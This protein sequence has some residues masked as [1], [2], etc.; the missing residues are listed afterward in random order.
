MLTAVQRNAILAASRERGGLADRLR[1]VLTIAGKPH[2]R[3]EET[4]YEGADGPACVLKT[5]V[6]GRLPLSVEQEEARV[7]WWVHPPNAKPVLCGGFKGKVVALDRG[8]GT[9]YVEAYTGGYEAARTP[10]G[11]SPAEDVFLRGSRPDD[12]L[13]NLLRGLPYSGMELGPFPEPRIW[14]DGDNKFM[15]HRYKMECAQD[16]AE[17]AELVL[18]DSP[19]NVAGAYPLSPVSRDAGPAW[20]FAEHEDT[21]SGGVSDGTPGDDQGGERYARVIAVLNDLNLGE[22]GVENFGRKVWARSAYILD[23]ITEE[24]DA[25]GA[26]FRRAVALSRDDRSVSVEAEYP[27]FWLARGSVIG[28]TATDLTGDLSGG[29]RVVSRFLFRASSFSVNVSDLRSSLSGIGPLLSEKEVPAFERKVFGGFGV[30]RPVIGRSAGLY[31]SSRLGWVFSDPNEGLVFHP[32]KSAPYTVT[33][34]PQEG[35]IVRG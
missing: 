4:T 20:E 7:D 17:E 32:D 24:A 31:F 33:R 35:V 12:A 23:E 5:T 28:A 15:W 13:Y 9:T 30:E 8:G 34:D 22:L 11:E 21:A 26:L 2:E 3:H 6:L 29:I 18:A 19:Q 16:V 14:R 25:H 10:V 1:P 27:A